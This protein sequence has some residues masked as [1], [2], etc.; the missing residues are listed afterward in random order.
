[1]NARVHVSSVIL[2]ALWVCAN[3]G[4]GWGGIVGPYAEDEFTLHL[5][6]LDEPAGGTTV[7]DVVTS[8]PLVLSVTGTATLGNP[9]YE[10]FGTAVQTGNGAYLSGGVQPLSRFTWTD[11]AFTFEAI[12]R[13][14]V[15]PLAAP[16]NMNIICGERAGSD[17]RSWQFR[18]TNAGQLNFIRLPRCRYLSTMVRFPRGSARPGTPAWCRAATCT[19]RSS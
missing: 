16:N 15:N 17:P 12:I 8:Q 18:I 13:P 14:D 5:W 2:L 4:I 9:S 1:M 6:H 19:G 7:A 11:G 10:A 3:P